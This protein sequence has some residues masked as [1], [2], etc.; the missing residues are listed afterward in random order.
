MKYHYAG[1]V[2]DKLHGVCKAGVKYHPGAVE[3]WEEA[4][5]KIPACAKS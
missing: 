3:A 5:F 4:G 2:D 1:S